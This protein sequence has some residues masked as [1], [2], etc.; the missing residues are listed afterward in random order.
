VGV[1]RFAGFTLDTDEARLERAGRPVELQPKVYQALRLF[2]QRPGRLVTRDELMEHL[3]PD[4][5]VN[6]EALTQIVRKLRRV[7]D[8]DAKEARYLQTV[9]K[10]G[11][12][13]LPEVNVVERTTPAPVEAPAPAPVETSA[14]RGARSLTRI[15]VVVVAVA[16]AAAAVAIAMVVLRPASE[17]SAPRGLL[18]ASRLT[19]TVEREQEPAFAPAGDQLV[20]V[21]NLDGQYDVFLLS[22]AGGNRVRL[23][24]TPEDEVYPQVSPDGRT[25]L[26]TRHHLDGHASARRISRFGGEEE[27]LAADARGAV[28]SPDGREILFARA[29]GGRHALVRKRIDGGG[30]RIVAHVDSVSSLRW[31]PGGDEAAFVDEHGVWLVPVDG[32]APRR[33][34]SPA[35]YVRSVAWDPSGRSL[36]TD[37]NWG[38]RA[39]LWRLPLDGGAPAALTAGAGGTY[40]PVAS[41]DGSRIA[42]AQEHKQNQLWIEDAAGGGPRLLPAKVTLDC[43]DVSADGRT[44]AYGDYDAVQ[45]R[46]EIGLL[47]ART[48]E[49][50]PLAHGACP[51]LSPDGQRVAYLRDGTEGAELW[52]VDASTGET[53]PLGTAR[54]AGQA[55]WSP[56]GKAIAFPAA[57]GLRLLSVESGRETLLAPGDY[58]PPAWSPD[59]AWLAASAHGS[60]RSGLYLVPAAGGEPTRIDARHSF[61]NPPL[62][63]VDGSGV[64]ILVDERT[65]P[66]LVT[67]DRAGRPIAERRLAFT[68]DPSF[69]G[70]FAVRRLRDGWLYLQERYESDLYLLSR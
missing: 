30:E 46:E 41:P 49:A 23:T 70:I 25:V 26:F 69:W 1:F 50:R 42:Y 40:H 51:A 44:I 11:Y 47:D 55:A 61:R 20:Y 28:W 52:I 24:A 38:G 3:W 66:R 12:R 16:V 53:G 13:F 21:A 64:S 34:G 57:D 65:A 33:I 39:N 35:E 67:I 60:A 15:V 37:A 8:D 9:L 19:F 5:H 14:P 56:D 2:V 45:R 6:E 54:P 62:W 29:G 36:L 31:S 22:I 17:P 4:T 59:G 43:L 58:G 27:L 7:L 32:G 18:R 63:E 48:L 68:P 10:Q